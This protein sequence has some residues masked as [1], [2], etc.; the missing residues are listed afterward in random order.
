MWKEKTSMSKAKKA[1]K[2]SIVIIVVAAIVAIFSSIVVTYE[3]EYKLVRV[4][5]KVD[6]VITE[7][8]ISFK[9]PFIEETDTIPKQI[10]LYDLPASDVITKDKKTMVADTYVLWK[11]ED[12]LLFAQTLS[13]SVTNAEGRINAAAFN[14]LKEVIGSMTQAEVISARDG[15]LSETI[16]E[17][18]GDTMSQYGIKLVNVETKHL[19]L[20][21]DNKTAV[22]ERMISERNQMAAQYTAEGDSQSQIIK[23]TTDKDV[24]IMISEAEAQAEQIIA[25]GEAQYMQILSEAYADPSKSE[26]YSFV[27]SLDAAKLS[28][29]G[30]NKTL[31]LTKDSPIAQIFTMGN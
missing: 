25:E 27:R 2:I 21:S 16:E 14:A 20:P 4:F 15:L 22:Y 19:D 23:N 29:T 10:L 30:N 8:G 6:R 3:N 1:G 5:G 31:I 13:A 24:A 26:F 11:I 9:I 17:R 18:I 28:L 7:E 12:P